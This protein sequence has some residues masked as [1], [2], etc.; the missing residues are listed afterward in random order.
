MKYLLDKSTELFKFGSYYSQPITNQIIYWALVVAAVTILITV[1]F[2]F[3]SKK[4][5]GVSLEQYGV[6]LNWKKVLINLLIAVTVVVG[7]YFVL[8]LLEMIFNTDFRI[9]TWAVRTFKWSHVVNAL[10]YMPL[11]FI[12]YFIN[13]VAINAN[14][15]GKSMKGW[16]GYL[17]A[18]LINVG[19]LIGYLILQY[20]KLFITGVANNPDQS[21]SPILLFALIPTLIVSTIYTKKLYEKTNSVYLGAFLN[22]ILLTMITVANTIVYTSIV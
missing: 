22:T 8:F 10:K 2:H 4:S 19:G 13:G 9:W 6:W 20:G 11:F 5:Q 1:A 16:K 14:T 15:N 17:V 3:F 12:F 7:G 21:L 18:I